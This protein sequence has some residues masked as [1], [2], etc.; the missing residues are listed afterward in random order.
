MFN[1]VFHWVRNYTALAFKYREAKIK[2]RVQFLS[3]NR[4]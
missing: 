3:Y 2:S 4:N 1:K